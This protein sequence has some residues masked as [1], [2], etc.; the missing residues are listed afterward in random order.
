[1][2]ILHILDHSVPLHSGYAFRT[3]AIIAQQRLF[4]WQTAHLTSSKH[5][6]ASQMEEDIDGL[7]FYRTIPNSTIF[8][9]IPILG[10]YAVIHDL[11]CRLEEVVSVVHPDILHV[12]SPCLN[13]IAALSVGRKKNIP[14]V[15]EL[16]ASWEDAAVSHGTTREGSLRYRLSRALETYVLKR[17]D[18]ITT[19]C[20]GLREDIVQRGISPDRVAVIPNAVDIERFEVNCAPDPRLIKELNLEGKRIIGFIGSF[21]TYEGL[22]LL[23]HSL[24][25]ILERQPETCILLV[26]G[27]PQ[28]ESLK[29]I[30]SELGISGKVIFTGRVPHSQVGKYYDLIEVL[31]YPRLATRLT[32]IVTP[33]KPLEAMARKRLFIASDVG[34]HRELIRHGVTGTLFKADNCEALADSVCNLLASEADWSERLQA[35]RNY[36]ETERNWCVS[37]S[38]Y[39]PVYERILGHEIHVHLKKPVHSFTE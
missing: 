27:G 10:Q 32:E 8:S 11:Q 15:Y 24:P 22:E 28:E 33:L 26:G 4:G 34:G 19:I 25:R 35:A 29:R 17:A 18:A 36:V 5:Y 23:L 9:R 20:E 16:R 3:S 31:V 21:Y 13:G 2:R 7:H 1:M 6:G 30:A 39:I 12:H 38:K 14:V 37:V